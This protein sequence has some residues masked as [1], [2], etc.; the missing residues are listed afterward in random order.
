MST[1]LYSM[2]WWNTPEFC[3]DSQQHQII[4][5]HGYMVVKV[6]VF[7]CTITVYFWGPKIDSSVAHWG[8]K[9]YGR[10]MTSHHSNDNKL[11]TLRGWICQC[12]QQIF[13]LI[14]WTGIILRKDD[15]PV[16]QFIS[17]FLKSIDVASPRLLE[18]NRVFGFSFSKTDLSLYTICLTPPSNWQEFIRDNQLRISS[19]RKTVFHTI[20]LKLI[21]IFSN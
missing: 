8:Q 1:I 13:K 21:F 9:H 17:E 20:L 11:L 3:T 18:D 15:S 7:T 6:K 14:Y 5:R 12:T 4:L 19:I 10:V 16:A 2:N